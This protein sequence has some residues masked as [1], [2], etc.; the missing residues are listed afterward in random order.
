[1]VKG[2]SNPREFDYQK[3][4]LQQQI[5][6]QHFIKDSVLILGEINAFPL[7]RFFI[8]LRAKLSTNIQ[9]WIT[10][11]RSAQIANALLLGQKKNLER[12]TQAA[13]STAGAMHVLAVSGL[14]VG[15]IYG[16][17]FLFFK[18]LQLPLGKRIVFLVSLIGLIWCYAFLTGLSPSVL[19]SATMFTLMSLA[20]LFNRSPSIFNP[21]AISAVLLLMFD[22][23][24]GFAVGFQLSYAALTGILL[25]QP[26]ILKIWLPKNKVLEYFWQISSVSIAAQI[27][28]FPISVYYF[29]TF[30]TY[31]LIANLVVIPAAFLI[32]A[33]GIPFLLLSL[34]TDWAFILG[35]ALNQLLI[36]LN[37]FIFSISELPFAQITQL[38]IEPWEILFYYALLLLL[39]A[40]LTSPSKQRLIMIY[41][42]VS[43]FLLVVYVEKFSDKE[44]RELIVFGNIKGVAINYFDGVHLYEYYDGVTSQDINFKVSAYQSQ[45]RFLSKKKLIVK[46]NEG[47]AVVFLPQIA[48]PVYV[49]KI[50]KSIQIK[51]DF[52]SYQWEGKDWESL[53]GADTL[54]FRNKAIKLKIND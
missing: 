46:E 24:V 8:E 31:F 35:E 41:G 12:E 9:Q 30:P 32:M 13:Y 42:L 15:I 18:P 16:F 36:Y 27:A 37:L 11:S 5:S 29:H 10:N 4:L 26:L 19:R 48:D 43:L 3:F 1:L 49:N 45:Q 53:Q 21:V 17:F 40:F 54:Y 28:T 23:L 22:P 50:S 39:Y 47:S 25:F 44:H 20:L 38:T 33:I 14:H 7:E 52:I 34:L 2:P 6:H 51:S